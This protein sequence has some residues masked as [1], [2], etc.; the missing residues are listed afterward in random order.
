MVLKEQMDDSRPGTTLRDA[1]RLVRG[2]KRLESVTIDRQRDRGEANGLRCVPDCSGC[3]G[4]GAAGITA[5]RARQSE[6]LDQRLNRE[7]LHA[8]DH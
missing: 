2:E 6:D 1:Q 3:L 5:V 8:G 4:E 7:V